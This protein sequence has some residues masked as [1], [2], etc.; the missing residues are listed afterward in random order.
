[1]SIGSI[2][3]SERSIADASMTSLRPWEL[4]STERT[5]FFMKRFSNFCFV[6]NV[7]EFNKLSFET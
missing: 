4:F 6:S 2:S 7:I 5:L 3:Q 1:M